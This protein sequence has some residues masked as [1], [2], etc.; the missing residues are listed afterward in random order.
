[1]WIYIL[2]LGH[3]ISRDHRISAHCGLVARAFGANGII[4]SGERDKSLLESI[5][6]ITKKWGGN[7]KVLYKRNWKKVIKEWEGVKVHL[8]MYGLPVQ[9]EIK[10]II[11]NKRDMLIVI[12]SEKV[13]RDVYELV[14][15]NISV[16]NQ[17]HSEVAA[18]SVFLHEYFNGKELDKKFS[19]ARVRIIPQK[20]GK[21]IVRK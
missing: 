9:M 18:L 6:R 3:R 7:F 1:M 16:T 14:D 12:G 20:R 5:E 4:Y 10:K 8:T 19:K 21:I 2:R 15:Y 11:K 13:P 17:P